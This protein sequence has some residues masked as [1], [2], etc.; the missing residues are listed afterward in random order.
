MAEVKLAIKDEIPTLED[1]K[2]NHIYL[3]AMNGSFRVEVQFE[4][5]SA[6]SAIWLTHQL[7]VAC[8][9]NYI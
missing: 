1:R 5:T 8:I 3:D 9:E 6:S 2:T 4:D 7:L